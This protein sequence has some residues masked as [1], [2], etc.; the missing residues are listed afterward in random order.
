MNNDASQKPASDAPPVESKPAGAWQP[1]T[2]RGVAAFAQASWARVVF[3]ISVIALIATVMVVWFIHANY[4]PPI[5]EAIKN[6]P[7]EAA[8]QNGNLTNVVSSLLT[9][10]KFLSA[11]IDLE[12]TGSIG[13]T[14]DLQLELRRD[15]FQIC[16]LFGCGLFVYPTETIYIG[17]STAEPWWGAR[18]PIILVFCSV[19]TIVALLSSWAT[20]TLLYAPIAKITAY[21]A[22]RKL[23]L[24]ESWRL[25]FAAQMPGAL[26][27]C[28]TI[29]FYGI[30]V[31]DLI[32]FLFFF[33]L[34]FLIVWIYLFAAVYSFPLL[35]ETTPAKTNP[36][37]TE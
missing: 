24:G 31:F 28:L 34:H 36:F 4:F 33:A 9:Q 1:F 22:D 2:P 7:D 17:R 11:V 37:S 26:L 12:E 3:F 21:F 27:M 15:Y 32:R 6:L 5:S 19:I 23:S 30:Q 8:L 18:Q 13:Q 29:F 25:A 10:K 35:S 20:F 14:A 16:S